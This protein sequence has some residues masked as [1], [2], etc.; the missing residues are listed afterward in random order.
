MS[1][2]PVSLS[3]LEIH[4]LGPFRIAVDGAPVEERQWARRKPKLLIKLLALQ[5][6][7][8]LHREQIIEF[9]WPE[10]DSEA[11]GANLHKTVHLARRA[12][13][14]ESGAR[15]NPR[16]IL[17]QDQQVMLRASGELW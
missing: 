13:E 3:R 8:Q 6:H 17:T 14:P 9:L 7:H 16:F 1:H 2:G 12:L 10:L 15:A 5:P 11:A 4:L